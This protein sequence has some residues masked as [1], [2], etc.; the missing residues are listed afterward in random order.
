MS[1]KAFETVSRA[2]RIEE[3]MAIVQ[4]DGGVIID[5]L[6]DPNLIAQLDEEIRPHLA[7]RG[8]NTANGP[9][10]AAFF[11]QCTKRMTNLVTR[12]RI[13]RESMLDS[14]DLLQM[15]DA[16]LLPYADSYWMNTAILAEIH[17]GEN[18]QSL[19][20]DLGNYPFF[21]TLGPS[22]PEV[23]VNCIV[24]VTDFTEEIGATRV[25]PGSH[26]WSD[27]RDLGSQEQ[28]LPAEMEAGSA[29]FY[30][31]KL[32][33]GAGA[34]RT[35]DRRRRAVVMNYNL[36]WL[37]PEEAYPFTVPLEVAKTLSPRAQQL[38]GFRTFH[39]EGHGG[40]KL[41]SVDY[42]DLEKYLGL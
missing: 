9:E 21:G 39:N 20:R 41:W 42:E 22:G 6:F 19:H 8:F 34:N 4:R 24:A 40:G 27:Y 23:S 28:T 10:D 14:D 26:L 29:L 36:G 32:V 5:R 38:I 7:E 13:F 33:H 2:T 1:K 18:L 25:I 17:P 37:V 31:A 15:I 30:S 12:S 11:G 35:R 16:M 3:I